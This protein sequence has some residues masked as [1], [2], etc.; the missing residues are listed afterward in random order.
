[1][2]EKKQLVE[3]GRWLRQAQDDLKACRIL[4]DAGMRAQAG[5]LAQQAAE[6]G[7]KAVE[8]AADMDPRGHSIT[9]LIRLLP[10]DHPLAALRD[11]ALLLDKLYI[12]TRY[13]DAIPELIPSEAFSEDEIERAYTAAATILAAA[14]R[15]LLPL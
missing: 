14:A 6:K 2:S 8:Y 1:M 5:F 13:P 4:L 11:Q 15:A 12:P 10:D 9:R 3:G 7:V